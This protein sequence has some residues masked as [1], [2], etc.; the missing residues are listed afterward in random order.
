MTTAASLAAATA[1]SATAVLGYQVRGR[2]A[3]WLAPSVYHGAKD[4]PAIALTFDDGPTPGSAQLLA[5]LARHKIPATFFQCG[6]QVRRHGS[7]AQEIATAGHEIGNHT[8][9]HPLLCFRSPQFMKSELSRTQESINKATGQTP[10]LFRAPYGVRWFGLAAAQRL[11]HLLGVM[12]TVIARDWVLPAPQIATRLQ[13]GARN[14]AIFC[15]HDG[16]GLTEAP[17]IRATIGAVERLVPVL[18]AAGYHFETVSQ[19][20]CPTNSRN[21]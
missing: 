6:T 2:S 21:A 12:W 14:G 15:L 4:R 19:I 8:D 16:R 7:L 20:L 18:L 3:S 17:D 13:K 9:T 5:V 10:L 1:A 11:H